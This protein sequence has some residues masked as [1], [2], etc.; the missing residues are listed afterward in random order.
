LETLAEGLTLVQADLTVFLEKSYKP[1]RNEQAIRRIHRL[2]QTRPVTV[3]DYVTPGTVDQ[4]IR[5]L[6][7]SKTD[8]RMRHLA[9]ARFASLL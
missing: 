3:L 9:A 2:G 8:R 6:L 4:R 7:A 1:S 5:S